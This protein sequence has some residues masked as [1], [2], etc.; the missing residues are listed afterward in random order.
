MLKLSSQTALVVDDDP[1]TRAYMAV[2]LRRYG[3]EVLEAADGVEALEL[4]WGKKPDFICLDLMLPELSGLQVC[5]RVR[6]DVRT[7]HIPILVVTARTGLDD[8]AYAMEAG[9]NGFLDK[10]FRRCA[11]LASLETL[12]YGRQQSNTSPV[13]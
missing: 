5:Q 11:F 2:V 7:Q 6:E 12:L 13:A 1:D 3:C 9:A 4:T 10:P 8:R